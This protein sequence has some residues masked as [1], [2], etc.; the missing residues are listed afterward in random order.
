[1]MTPEQHSPVEQLLERFGLSVRSLSRLKLGR[2]LA[3]N[4]T[5][6]TVVTIMACMVIAWGVPW[7]A[8]KV[9]SILIMAGVGL[10][11]LRRLEVI[12][13]NHPETALLEGAELILWQQQQ[14]ELESKKI[15]HPPQQPAQ[16]YRIPPEERAL[17]EESAIINPDKET[18]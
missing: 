9:M 8:A 14:L 6:I 1:M 5:T 18:P 10:Y 7:P 11:T 16:A 17:V 15:S 13:R 3:G 2:G 12:V 4:M